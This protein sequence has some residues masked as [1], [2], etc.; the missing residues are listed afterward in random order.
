MTTEQIQALNEWALHAN[1]EEKVRFLNQL[2]AS[3]AL[4]IKQ[5]LLDLKQ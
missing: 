4:A 2:K 5:K 1:T 3:R